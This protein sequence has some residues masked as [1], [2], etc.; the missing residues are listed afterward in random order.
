MNTPNLTKLL[1]LSASLLFSRAE[2]QEIDYS[3]EAQLNTENYRSN[4]DHFETVVG[5]FEA[6][7]RY[8]DSH[9]SWEHK[10]QEISV[11]AFEEL[12]KKLPEPEADCKKYISALKVFTAA[13]KNGNIVMLYQPFILLKSNYS[14]DRGTRFD[15][16]KEGGY[17]IYDE[18]Q[19]AFITPPDNEKTYMENY[20]EGMRSMKYNNSTTYSPFWTSAATS[21]NGDTRYAIVPFQEISSILY[22]SDRKSKADK[23]TI[24]SAA[25]IFTRS[26]SVRKRWK[27]HFILKATVGNETNYTN[28]FAN[29]MNLC[30]PDCSYT[31]LKILAGG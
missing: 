31:S 12:F 20:A 15:G 16:G 30:P 27:H 22:S 23:F 17:F 7:F 2:A 4:P 5:N 11:E 10:T 24:V 21:A 26:R 8:G 13:D 9:D 19:K 1:L 3:C 28:E 25:S 14:N 18:A 29:H 6:K